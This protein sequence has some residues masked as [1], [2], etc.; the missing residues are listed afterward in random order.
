MLSYS[1]KSS[2]SWCRV[3]CREYPPS[4]P[5]PPPHPTVD[6]AA[7]NGWTRNGR[8]GPPTTTCVHTQTQKRFELLFLEGKKTR[9]VWTVVVNMAR[10]RCSMFTSIH[11]Y[12]PLLP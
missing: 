9:R 5:A 3:P 4:N 1:H 11:T 7:R 12:P 6:C 2:E 10:G 8:T